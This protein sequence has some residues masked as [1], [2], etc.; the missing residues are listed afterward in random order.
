MTAEGGGIDPR[1][2]ENTYVLEEKAIDSSYII[3]PK[4]G[5]SP[6]EQG[7]IVANVCVAVRSR[8]FPKYLRQTRSKNRILRY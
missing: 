6:T 4:P 2:L 3:G 7:L 5:V 1:Q 8:A